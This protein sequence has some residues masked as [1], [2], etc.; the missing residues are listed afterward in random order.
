MGHARTCQPRSTMRPRELHARCVS[1]F[2]RF[3]YCQDTNR[4]STERSMRCAAAPVGSAA[5]HAQPRATGGACRLA[6]DLDCSSCQPAP[7]PPA[8]ELTARHVLPWQSPLCFWL[9]ASETDTVAAI[10]CCDA[11]APAA[12]RVPG[13]PLSLTAASKGMPALSLR[14][15]SQRLDSN[16]TP[17]P[18]AP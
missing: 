2:A 1:A 4:I 16:R 9:A 18:L 15:T 11:A 6:P 8:R 17:P 5:L 12:A 13:R 7:A 10:C 3:V 14:V